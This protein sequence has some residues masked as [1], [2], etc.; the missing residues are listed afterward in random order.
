[1]KV[2]MPARIFWNTGDYLKAQLPIEFRR[3]ETVRG[4]DDLRI[5]PA[6]RAS[7]RQLQEAR[8]TP[9]LRCLSCTHTWRISQH[10]PH[11]C[12]QSPATTS[13]CSS[14]LKMA[15]PSESETPVSLALNSYSRSFKEV[16]LGRRWIR[17]HDEVRAG[18]EA[19]F[20][21]CQAPD[22]VRDRASTPRSG[23]SVHRPK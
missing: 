22:F 11:V 9:S 1:M 19:S 16:V 6:R 23:F 2:L 14:R 13:P 10:P 18:Y 8:P 4:Q 21:I 15:R 7:L 17:P 12:P 3:L 20:P 5:A